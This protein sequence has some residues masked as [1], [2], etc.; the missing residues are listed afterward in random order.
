MRTQGKY[1][2]NEANSLL[3]R[4]SI[5]AATLIAKCAAR[6]EMAFWNQLAFSR[7]GRFPRRNRPAKALGNCGAFPSEDFSPTLRQTWPRE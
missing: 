6:V 2:R 5:R 1:E 4:L 3:F 7:A